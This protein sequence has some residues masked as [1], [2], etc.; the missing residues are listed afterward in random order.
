MLDSVL[1]RVLVHINDSPTFL[2]RKTLVML[3]L[4][5]AAAARMK[6]LEAARYH[7]HPN[8]AGNWPNRSSS[9]IPPF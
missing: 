9:I 1:F 2:I 3:R 5:R 6:V 7:I 4:T 8:R